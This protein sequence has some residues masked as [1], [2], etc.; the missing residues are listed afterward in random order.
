MEEN[1]I[2]TESPPLAYMVDP[3]VDP[4]EPDLTRLT[5]LKTGPTGSSLK[6]RI[7]AAAAPALSFAVIL[8]ERSPR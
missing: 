7:K 1:S 8:N 3:A 5:P 4:G 6:M 2:R